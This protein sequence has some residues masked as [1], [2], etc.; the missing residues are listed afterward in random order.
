MCGTCGDGGGGWA[1]GSEGVGGSRILSAPLCTWAWSGHPW[2]GARW[3]WL[4]NR[5][6][7]GSK[8]VPRNVDY[9]SAPVCNMNINIKY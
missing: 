4:G 9:H 3:F 8:G 7:V 1:L 2:R 5:V 6:I